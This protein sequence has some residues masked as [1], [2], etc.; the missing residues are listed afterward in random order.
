MGQIGSRGYHGMSKD[1]LDVVDSMELV[2]S[3]KNFANTCLDISIKICEKLVEYISSVLVPV[4]DFF[5]YIFL[6]KYRSDVAK[7]GRDSRNIFG[8]M[9]NKAVRVHISNSSRTRELGRQVDCDF[10]RQIASGVPV[11]QR[12]KALKVYVNLIT[13]INFGYLD[14]KLFEDFNSM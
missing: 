9:A 13:I 3:V 2:G 5:F 10:E 4:N 8:H 12:I 7:L 6:S 11:A 1:D 14:L